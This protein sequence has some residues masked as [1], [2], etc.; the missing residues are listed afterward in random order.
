MKSQL[1]GRIREPIDPIMLKSL[2]L[3]CILIIGLGAGACHA[4]DKPVE[5]ESQSGFGI[6]DSRQEYYQFMGNAKRVAYGP[7]GNKELQAMIPMLN[8]IALNKPIGSTAGQ[9]KEAQASTIGLLSKESIRSEIEMVDQQ[10][11][12]LKKA[13]AR[14]QQKVAKEIRE[15]DFSKTA[16]VTSRIRSIRSNAQKE[17]ED[18]LLPHQVKRLR[19][20]HLQS[21]MKRQSLLDILTEDPVKTELEISDDQE[22]ELRKEEKK[23]EEE[24]EKEIQ[25]LRKEA[26]EKLLGKLKP[27]QEKKAKELLG[28]AFEF[29]DDAKEKGRK[30]GKGNFKK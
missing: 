25:K 24:L 4:Q 19:Q 29:G 22:S 2:T 18:L 30:K 16:T 9:Y 20:I 5:G 13:S 1:T 14:I 27:G 11:E 23:I 12:D 6:F 10:Y 28:E 17:L 7:N 8:D 3:V 15:I 26:Q 21:K